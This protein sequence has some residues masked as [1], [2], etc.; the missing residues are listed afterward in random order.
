MKQREVTNFPK[1]SNKMLHLAVFDLDLHG[2]QRFNFLGSLSISGLI[3]IVK[4]N[5]VCD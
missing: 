3:L 4:V 5:T 1:G 2:L